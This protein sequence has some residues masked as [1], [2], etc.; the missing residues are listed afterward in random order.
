MIISCKLPPEPKRQD[1]KPFPGELEATNAGCICPEQ[2][3]W[4]ELIEFDSNCSVHV[5]V[6][7][8]R[9]Q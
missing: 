4:P 8:P 2:E 6:K 3:K 1:F 7:S 9:I 5:L